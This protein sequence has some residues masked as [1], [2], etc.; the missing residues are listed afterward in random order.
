MHNDN[1]QYI[2]ITTFQKD[3]LHWYDENKRDLPWRKTLDPYKI[4][5]SEVM[6]QQTQVK[7]VIPY[8]ER[9][10][11]NFPTVYDLAAADEQFVL[12]EW[13]GLGYYSRARNL[14][15]AA[16]EVVQSYGGKLPRDGKALESLKGIG[17]YTRGAIMSIAYNKPEPAVDGNVMRV[18]SRLLKIEEDITEYRTKKIFDDVVRKTISK[19]D[20]RHFNQAI[21]E[22]GAL[23]CTPRQPKCDVCPIRSH[24]LAY[25][26]GIQQYLPNRKKQPKQRVISY[27]TVLIVSKNYE[28]IIEQRPENGL[29]AN[30]WQF[31]MINI[32]DI[33]TDHIEHY[34]YAEYGIPI[35]DLVKKDTLKHIFTHL[36]WDLTVYVARTDLEKTPDDRLKFISDREIAS[37][38]FPVPHLKM[39]K[40]LPF[41]EK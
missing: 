11:E 8:Y 15:E 3:L 24:C 34:L 5:V 39:M 20:A 28:V 21:M 7:T 29:L 2:D 6:L 27:A 36:I 10:M 35:N 32:D 22:L 26:A 37:Y 38:P 41:S 25:E 19:K 31:P 30:M 17:P 23:I 14:H 18:Y 1:L 4:W 13:E 16:K 9:F 33:G 12:K 40:H